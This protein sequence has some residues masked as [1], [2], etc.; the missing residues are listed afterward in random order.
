MTTIA[1]SNRPRNPENPIDQARAQGA[2]GWFSTD[3]IEII[4]AAVYVC[5]SEAVVVSYNRRATELWGRAPKLGDTDLKFC[6]SH[7]LYRLDGTLLPHPETPMEQVLRTSVA[8]RD[9]E[10]IIE[11]PDGSRVTVLV[12]IAPIFDDGGKLIGA[13]NC[14][15]DLSA[16]KRVENEHIQLREDLHQAQ[17]IQALGELT[18][19]IAHD[20]NN[21]IAEIL[22]PVIT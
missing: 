10:V 13:V 15:L 5:N 4:P 3:L 7:K 16:H 18:G 20:F 1:G 2:L 21:L 17:K 6:G 14:F 11:R 22:R 19:G 12:N 9:K 8:A